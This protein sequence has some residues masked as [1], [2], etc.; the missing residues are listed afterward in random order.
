[1]GV[2]PLILCAGVLT[3][4]CSSTAE[5]ASSSVPATSSST[6]AVDQQMVDAAVADLTTQLTKPAKLDGI[7]HKTAQGWAFLEANIKAPDGQW[8][9]YAGTPFAEAA[10]NGGKS[11]KYVGLLR[12]DGG[13]K[14]VTS[15]VGPTDV[16]WQDWSTEYSAPPE[17]FQLPPN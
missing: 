3:A 11:K 12:N 1:M 14:V 2:V 6:P 15:T 4:S 5:P 17:I 9:D 8:I 7:R 10:A 13:W 16:A